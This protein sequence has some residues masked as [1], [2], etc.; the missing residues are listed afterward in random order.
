[1]EASV[2][3]QLSQIIFMPSSLHFLIVAM[4]G[5]MAASPLGWVMHCGERKKFCISTITRAVV[6]VEIVSSFEGLCVVG[7]VI[8]GELGELLMVYVLVGCV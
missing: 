2:R 4:M 8:L 3:P 6:W 5:G 7:M 1:M